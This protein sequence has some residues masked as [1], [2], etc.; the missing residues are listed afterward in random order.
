MITNRSVAPLAVILVAGSTVLTPPAWADP[1][2]TPQPVAPAASP[3]TGRPGGGQTG[4]AP[5]AEGYGGAVSTVDPDASRAA[6]KVLRRGGNAVD[7]AVAAAA[8]LGVTEPYSAGL[9]G[10]GFLLYYDARR[11]KVHTIDGR[12]T[13][14]KAMTAT[15]LEGVP[16]EEA[17]TSGLSAG[18]PGS[19]AQWELAL[20]RFGTLSLRQALQ[21]AVEVADRGFTVDQTFHDQTAANAARFA[22]F[23]STAKLFLP[24]G[25][26]P[27]VGSTF[28]NPELAETYR[29]LGRKGPGW[30]YGGRLGEEVVA[31]VKRPPVTPGSARNVRPG[32][33]ELPDLR[34]YRALERPPTK[35]VYKGMDV[36]GMAPPSS[37]GSTVGEALNILEALPEV[38]PHEYLE[39][40]RLAFADRGRYVG[41][42]SGVPGV[43]LAELLS[44]GFAKERACLV[45]ERAMAH[46]APAGEPDG[47]YGPCPAD[48]PAA[49]ET[50]TAAPEGPETTHLVVADRRGNVVAYNITIESTGGNGIVVPGRGFLLNNELT[51][52]TFGPA[53]GD[54]NLPGP[55]KRPRS[56]MAPTIVLADGEPLLALGS[57]GGSTIITTVLQILVNRWEFGMSLPEALAA[58][59]ATQR[60]TAQ[61]QAEQGFIDRHGAELTGR[62]HSLVLN[63]EIGAATAV[64]FLGR[65]RLQAVAEP[66]RRGGGSALVVSPAR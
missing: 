24:G 14:P 60:N 40:S 62:G 35:V 16:F 9:A 22:D 23:T 42:P 55:G 66:S 19:V 50:G 18:V 57:P 59:R 61:T 20:R 2:P 13:A 51:D 28:R 31:T 12:E 58:P 21:P 17:V 27:R 3:T 47:A 49:P 37:G 26:P 45:T 33:M 11:G 63:P 10:G 15:S 65:G 25:A 6:L 56:S 1:P 32:L 39:A 46:P 41:D 53:P 34:A 30:L 64:E 7:A 48:S 8:V 29:T 44:D 38:G 52:F 4:K 36:Y 5:V 43:P 54:P